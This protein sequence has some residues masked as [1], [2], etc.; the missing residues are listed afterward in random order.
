[1]DAFFLS[2]AGVTVE[3]ASESTLEEAQVKLAFAATARRVVLGVDGS[4]LD[5]RSLAAGLE[6]GQVD[7]LVTDLEPASSRLRAYAEVATLR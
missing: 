7:T 1:V 4:K 6:W 2:A 3:G 5:Q